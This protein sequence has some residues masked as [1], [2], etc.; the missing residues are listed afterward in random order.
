[1]SAY[2]EAIFDDTVAMISWGLIC[3]IFV[4]VFSR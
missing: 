3:S 4:I 2:F 1:L